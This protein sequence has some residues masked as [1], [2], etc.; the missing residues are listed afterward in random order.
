MPNELS[1]EAAALVRL[2]ELAEGFEC[3]AQCEEGIVVAL[4]PYTNAFAETNL[5]SPPFPYLRQVRAANEARTNAER[6]RKDAAAIR[7][8]LAL[9]PTPAALG[10]Q[11][12][13]GNNA[14][15]ERA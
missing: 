4:Q 3:A 10:P 1:A 9:H 7:V 11:T 14:R 5:D 2:K 8:I 6:Y 15:G 13:G 12:N